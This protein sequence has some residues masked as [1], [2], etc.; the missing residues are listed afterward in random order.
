MRD[1]DLR[2]RRIAAIKLIV[3]RLED[4][5]K[6]KL[7]KIL[8]FTQEEIG[9]PLGYRF[10]MHHYGP[11]SEAVD[12]DISFMRAIGQLVVQPDESGFGF[13]IRSA[14]DEVL[15]LGEEV[16]QYKGAMTTAIDKLGKLD[17]P[18]LELWATTHFV[19]HLLKEPTRESVIENVGRLKPRFSPPTIRAA[20]NKLVQE[21]LMTDAP[22]N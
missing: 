21:N 7:Q 4:L 13:H 1:N 17:T 3:D 22:G 14:S 12:N 8:Y 2:A 15:E 10:R 11:F 5:G 19:Q 9:A 16:N 20:Y 18:D 6:T